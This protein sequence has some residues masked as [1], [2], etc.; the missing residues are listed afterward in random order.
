MTPFVVKTSGQPFV[1]KVSAFPLFAARRY[2][3]RLE[4]AISDTHGINSHLADGGDGV[5]SKERY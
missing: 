5:S 4:E 3:S 2:W 1:A